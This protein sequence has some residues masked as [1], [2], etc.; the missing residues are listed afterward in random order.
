MAKHGPSQAEDD[1]VASNNSIAIHPSL[2]AH[3]L[4]ASYPR[5]AAPLVP[6][7]ADD[8]L[9]DLLDFTYAVERANSSTREERLAAARLKARAMAHDDEDG[10]LARLCAIERSLAADK[11]WRDAYEA[12]RSNYSR[13]LSGEEWAAVQPADRDDAPP[14]AVTSY[15]VL[16]AL[17]APD[18]LRLCEY[19]GFQPAADTSKARLCAIVAYEIGVPVLDLPPLARFVAPGLG[20]P[21]AEDAEAEEAEAEKSALKKRTKR[22]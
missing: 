5:L 15:K 9:V 22:G 10:L 21:P 2:R 4:L 16:D 12:R 11:R 7:L 13:Y 20:G 6:P 18:L 17:D 14:I 1:P 19:Y 8:V 3:P